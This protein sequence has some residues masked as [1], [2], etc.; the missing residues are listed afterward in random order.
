MAAGES[1][2][3][4]LPT[5][6]IRKDQS[7][8]SNW[9]EID[10]KPAEIAKPTL[11]KIVA[12]VEQP[13]IAQQQ[14]KPDVA[15]EVVPNKTTGPAHEEKSSPKPDGPAHEEKSSP[16]PEP[17]VSQKKEQVPLKVPM[18]GLRSMKFPMKPIQTPKVAEPIKPLMISDLKRRVWPNTKNVKTK[19][20]ATLEYNVFTLHEAN[21]DIEDYYGH[22]QTEINKMCEDLG[23][24]DYQPV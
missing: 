2:K 7:S 13:N 6:P 17:I 12:L 9:V 24:T 10:E 3:P 8:G 11:T 19:I 5:T 22:I 14:P 16:K 4:T 21:K 15:A 18:G 1:E 23:T 20:I